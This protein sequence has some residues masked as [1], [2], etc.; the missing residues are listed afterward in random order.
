ML[1]GVLGSFGEIP[2][3]NKNK[4]I[5]LCMNTFYFLNFGASRLDNNLSAD[6]ESVYLNNINTYNMI[7]KL[8]HNT[9][10][11]CKAIN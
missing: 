6:S 10:P 7:T 5:R 1:T 8:T 2:K 11:R 9:A 3:Q 4:T